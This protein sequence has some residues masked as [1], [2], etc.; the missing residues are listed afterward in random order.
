MWNNP[1]QGI[2]AGKFVS[3]EETGGAFK[4][5]N[6]KFWNV[7]FKNKNELEKMNPERDIKLIGQKLGENSF[8]AESFREMRCGC[9]MKNC[10]CG[11]SERNFL[12]PRSNGCGMKIPN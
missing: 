5:S 8:Y 4:D 2:I 6:E 9:K 3:I 10:S 1:E 7:S 12:N 11:N